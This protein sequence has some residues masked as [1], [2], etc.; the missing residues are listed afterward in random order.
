MH[1]LCVV[2]CF[3]PAFLLFNFK[4]K[5][6]VGVINARGGMMVEEGESISHSWCLF[7]VYG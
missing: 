3:Q 6:G 4:Q 1:F 7:Q 5:V 2:F